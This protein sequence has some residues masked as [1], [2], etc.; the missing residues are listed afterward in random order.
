MVNIFV[1]TNETYYPRLTV[2]AKT[3]V[4]YNRDVLLTILYSDL[5]QKSR[6]H[7]ERFADK[8]HLQYRFLSVDEHRSESYQLIHQITEETYYRFLLL[9]IFPTEDR[10]MWMDIDA[11]VTGD[12][13]LYYNADFEEYAIKNGQCVF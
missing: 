1:A 8:I 10:A 2:F 12:L 4:K 7:F 6:K 9:D 5:S 3:L 13:S 11:V